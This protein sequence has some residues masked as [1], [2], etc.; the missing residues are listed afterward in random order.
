MCVSYIELHSGVRGGGEWVGV[1]ALL[2]DL[3]WCC[4]SSERLSSPALSPS[5]RA[6]RQVHGN[7]QRKNGVSPL[8]HSEEAENLALMNM[9]LSYS[10]SEARPMLLILA[11]RSALCSI[12]SL[13]SKA[14]VFCVSRR[15]S[16]F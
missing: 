10:D 9:R 15:F 13:I 2:V 6:V 14:L 3:H 8:Q 5:P 4:L 1:K 12:V 16:E 11:D 7:T